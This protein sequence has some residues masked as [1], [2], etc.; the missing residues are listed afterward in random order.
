[1]FLHGLTGSGKLLVLFQQALKGILSAGQESCGFFL[2]L[3]RFQI[4]GKVF[5]FPLVV[6]IHM[7]NLFAYQHSLS[8]YVKIIICPFFTIFTHSRYLQ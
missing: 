5:F 3:F 4:V 6:L 1:M 8:I 2:E 7:V